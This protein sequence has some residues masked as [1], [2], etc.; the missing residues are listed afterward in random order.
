MRFIVMFVTAVSVLF[1]SY[2]ATMAKD[3]ELLQTDI[4]W[5]EP[6]LARNGK[7]WVLVIKLA[8]NNDK[9]IELLTD[10]L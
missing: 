6:L 2:K 5:L 9:N 8:S 3:K 10:V 7:P 1:L 4:D